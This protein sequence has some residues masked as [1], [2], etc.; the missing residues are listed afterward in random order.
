MFYVVG[1]FFGVT[2]GTEPFWLR[3]LISQPR[4]SA[5]IAARQVQKQ[6]IT[7]DDDDTDSIVRHHDASMSQ[8]LV[9]CWRIFRVALFHRLCEN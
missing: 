9:Q 6:P 8:L 7:L 4:R 1:T 3:S 5:R 2:V